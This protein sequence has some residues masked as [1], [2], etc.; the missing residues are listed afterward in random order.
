MVESGC[1]RRNKLPQTLCYSFRIPPQ[2]PDNPLTTPSSHSHRPNKTSQMSNN[3]K[4]GIRIVF[5]I[6]DDKFTYDS[7]LFQYRR[8][9]ASSISCTWN[10]LWIRALAV[11]MVEGDSQLPAPNVLYKVLA[12]LHLDTRSWPKKS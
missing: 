2:P 7:N 6:L 3:T 9:L 8:A 5:G 11:G 10:R 1:S 12:F 4:S